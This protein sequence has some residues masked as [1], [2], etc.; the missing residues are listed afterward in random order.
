MCFSLFTFTVFNSC[1][2]F[3]MNMNM[4]IFTDTILICL[5]RCA[6]IFSS[7]NVRKCHNNIK[8]LLHS[9]WQAYYIVMQRFIASSLP[10]TNIKNTSVVILTVVYLASFLQMRTS[11]TDIQ[12]MIRHISSTTCCADCKL[13]YTYR[14]MV[15]INYAYAYIFAQIWVAFCFEISTL[16]M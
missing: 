12:V 2:K 10:A 1:F 15:T 5:V 8:Q 6:N 9:L 11:C 13:Q 14:S 3:Y 16:P 4:H 7:S